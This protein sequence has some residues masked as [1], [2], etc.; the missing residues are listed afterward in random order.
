MDRIILIQHR[1]SVYKDNNTVW[2][3]TYWFI[4]VNVYTANQKKK[5]I[6]KEFS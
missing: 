5:Y 6:Y 4:R 1:N 3:V 2:S